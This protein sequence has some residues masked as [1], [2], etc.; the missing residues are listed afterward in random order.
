[1]SGGSGGS[2]SG[3]RSGGGGSGDAGQPGEVVRAANT[4]Q[5][6]IDRG[7]IS[8]QQLPSGTVQLT[9]A[10]ATIRYNKTSAELWASRYGEKAFKPVA[11]V[12]FYKNRV[13]ALR[14]FASRTGITL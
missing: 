5:A 8:A 12:K 3:G 6:A 2:G 14:E 4:L 11:P 1:M 7:E 9:H 13:D 10:N